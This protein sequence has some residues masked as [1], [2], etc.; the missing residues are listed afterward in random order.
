MRRG[1]VVAVLLAGTLRLGASPGR[2][3]YSN[4]ST[5]LLNCPAPGSANGNVS[6]RLYAGIGEAAGVEVHVLQPGNGWVPWWRSAQYPAD[7]HY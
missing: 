1:L 3:L 4:D 5:N 2:L 7:E 6:Q